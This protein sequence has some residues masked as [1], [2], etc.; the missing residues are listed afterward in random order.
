LRPGS[1]G[2]GGGGGGTGCRLS[3]IESSYL[4]K[5]FANRRKSIFCTGAAVAGGEKEVLPVT[6]SVDFP[7]LAEISATRQYQCLCPG[8]AGSGGGGGTGCSLSQRY[9]GSGGHSQH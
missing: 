4:A 7:Y 3:Q 2:S 9:H 8:T 1:A 6:P 5:F